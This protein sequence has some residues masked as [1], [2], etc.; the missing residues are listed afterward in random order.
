M[1][2]QATGGAMPSAS[3]LVEGVDFYEYIRRIHDYSDSLY[4]TCFNSR[5]EK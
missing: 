5:N 3:S 1:L 4:F 2:T